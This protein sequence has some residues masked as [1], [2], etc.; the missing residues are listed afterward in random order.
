M[1]RCQERRGWSVS[2]CPAGSSTITSMSAG[3][4]NKCV[5]KLI[6]VRTRRGRA[7]TTLALRDHRLT[8]G[9]PAQHHPAIPPPPVPPSIVTETEWICASCVRI[10]GV[11]LVDFIS[12]R[13]HRAAFLPL[14]GSPVRC[15]QLPVSPVTTLRRLLRVTEEL[16]YYYITSVVW[17]FPI[18]LLYVCVFVCLHDNVGTNSHLTLFFGTVVHLDQISVTLVRS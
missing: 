1:S 8:D 13:H 6:V 4:D 18:G 2:Q 16:A 17:S 9:H 7:V 5:G 11:R 3:E 12:N 10:T 15:R 14:Y